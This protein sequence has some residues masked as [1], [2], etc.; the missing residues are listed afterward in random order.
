MSAYGASDV[1]RDFR[2]E[3]ASLRAANQRLRT[4]LRNLR[5]KCDWYGQGDGELDEAKAE[6]DRALQ[7]LT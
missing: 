5:Q 7:V 3:A 1:A 6:A 4:A 2:D